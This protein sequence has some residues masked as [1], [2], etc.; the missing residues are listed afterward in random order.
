MRIL[1]SLALAQLWHH[2][3]RWALLAAGIALVVAVPVVTAGLATSVSAQTVR[4]TVSHFD[5]TD[6]TL[7]V[8]QEAD[9]LIRKG[10]RRQNDQV[11]RAQLATLTTTP[12]LRELLFRQLTVEGSSFLLGGV[13]HLQTAVRLISGRLPRSC[14]PTR[15]EVVVVGSGDSTR[16]RR[17]VASLGAIV[18]GRVQRT[19]PLLV[20]GALDP[21]GEPLV[22]GADVD[23]IAALSS[24]ELFA[25]HYAWVSTVDADRIV[26]L[27]VS[28]YIARSSSVD[29]ELATRVGGTSFER[30]DEQLQQAQGRADVSGRRFGLLGGFA[31]V[32]LLGFA[33]VAAIGLRRE[34]QLLISVL[35]RRGATIGQVGGVTLIEAVLGALGGA[36]LG[37]VL[38]ATVAAALS[39]G[40]GH[41]LGGAAAQALGDAALTA[42]LLTIA[43]AAV[44]LAVL[45]WPDAQARAVWRTLDLIAIACFAAAVLAG[46]RGSAAASALASSND[47]LVVALPVL[48]SIV[49]G[50]VAAR[51]WG[52]AARLAE[53]LLPRRSVAG[54]IG[55]LGAIRRPLRPVATVAFLTAAV[56]S[57]VF[58]GAYRATLLAN[59]AD[60]AAYQVPLDVTV[61]PSSTVL[62]PNVTP[63]AFGATGRVFGVLRTSAGITRLAGVTDSVPVVAVDS[64]ALPLAHDWRRTTGSSES[65]AALASALRGTSSRA[66]ELSAGAVPRTIE[67]A[68]RGA[69]AEATFT[70]WL[71]TGA[72]REVTVTLE[73]R[74]NR[75]VGTIPALGEQPVQ[76]VAIGVDESADY[77]TRHAHTVGEGNTD[78]PVL[79][80]RIILGPPVVAGVAP[81]WSWAGWGSLLGS[82]RS[83]TDSLSLSYKIISAPVIAAPDFAAVRAAAVPVAVDP[84]TAREAHNGLLQLAIDPSTTVTA[85]LVATLPRLP[86]APGRFVLADR[87]AFAA[88][89]DLRD[90]GT[91]PSEFWVLASSAVLDRALAAPPFTQLTVTRRSALQADLDSDPVGRGARLVLV[92]VALL[93]L[94][95]GAV[96]LILLVFGER[97]DGAGE[98]YAWEADGTRPSTLRRMLLVRMA[99]VAA[100]AVPVGVVAGLVLARV[101]TSL[102]AVDASGGTPTPPLA[103]TLGSVWTPL[104]LLAGIG[105]GLLLGWVV[106]ARSL[107]EPY[108]AAADRDLR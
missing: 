89:L 22:L 47:P 27:G 14:T 29:N 100:V 6:R 57:V 79:S 45:V 60:Q 33:V 1:W 106:A 75:L 84:Q 93:A 19:N 73:P 68:A 72:G 76:L 91:N 13:D 59:D 9:S 32:L 99:A 63:N 56:A 67:F 40:T 21:Q 87:A 8:S 35:A 3:G 58:A 55:L 38:G 18:V 62:V 20:S 17:A 90:P 25:R 51:V 7:L 30:P 94:A 83:R 86:T 71:R 80:G 69:N 16:L 49:A 66:P 101:G 4:R 82:V 98:L 77:A 85:R 36:L 107:R 26:A 46:D 88:A 11:V 15:C 5:I 81:R 28:G 105:V 70:A 23:A 50:L 103:V 34:S 104:A 102:V 61:T 24:L 41:P 39:R 37:A 54:R 44:T 96:A 52:P 78:V 42:G 31:A 48:A 2:R 64:A 10:T 92:V 43:T 53:R 97:R 108:P 95:V 74:G 65:A 12:V